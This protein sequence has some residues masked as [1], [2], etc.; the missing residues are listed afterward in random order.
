M[1][2]LW[3]R[4]RE[5]QIDIILAVSGAHRP[6]FVFETNSATVNTK[7]VWIS[8]TPLTKRLANLGHYSTMGPLDA[9]TS[10]VATSRKSLTPEQPEVPD[11]EEF[12]DSPEAP[13]T[14]E[15]MSGSVSESKTSRPIKRR[16]ARN[17]CVW[18]RSD[19]SLSWED[20]QSQFSQ[21]FPGRTFTGI[22]NRFNDYLGKPHLS[23]FTS[24]NALIRKLREDD[25]L[26]WDDV[27]K[28]FSEPQLSDDLR[29]TESL[30]RV[31]ARDTRLGLAFG[32]PSKDDLFW[33][34]RQVPHDEWAITKCKLAVIIRRPQR[35]RAGNMKIVSYSEAKPEYIVGRDTNEYFLKFD[36]G[37]NV[38]SR[39]GEVQ[40]PHGDPGIIHAGRISELEQTKRVGWPCF[41]SN[42]QYRIANGCF[43]LTQ[44]IIYAD[45]PDFR[46]HPGTALTQHPDIAQIERWVQ[47]A[48][49]ATPTHRGKVILVF[50]D[51][52]ASIG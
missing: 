19:I 51:C 42:T 40:I 30:P 14:L 33:E 32:L 31:L 34:A 4:S 9:D 5:P 39:R 44:E 29:F 47:S 25:S 49:R 2:H 10:M 3:G 23:R 8:I 52:F 22:Q 26:T 15:A 36:A 27:A 35:G 43:D 21:H 45:V 1:L 38:A 7:V 20:V 41:V 46:Y 37:L 48:Y 18:L 17:F 6:A 28:R 16:R 11:N 12:S 50:F 24:E 13:N